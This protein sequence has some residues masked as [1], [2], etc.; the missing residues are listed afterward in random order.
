M[1]AIVKQILSIGLVSS[2]LLLA[3][4]DRS[5]KQPDFDQTL[6]EAQSYLLSGQ[7][8]SALI[9]SQNLLRMQPDSME[10]KRLLSDTFYTA[11]DYKSA[12]KNYKEILVKMDPNAPEY[13]G[14]FSKYIE[15]LTHLGQSKEAIANLDQYSKSYTVTSD[16]NRLYGDAALVSNNF[17]KATEY[18]S[19]SL[20]QNPQNSESLL[21]MA[22]ANNALGQ[23]EKAIDWLNQAIE[24][25]TDFADALIF[26][27]YFYISQKQP[28]LA[29]ASFS[30]AIAALGK[31]DIMTSQRYRAIH[32]LS[33]A[34]VDQGRTEEALRLNKTLADSPQ[35]KIQQSLKSALEAYEQGDSGLAGEYFEEVLSIS[36]DNQLSNLGLGMIKLKQGDIETAEHLLSQASK[37]LEGLNE[38][39]IKALALARLRLSKYEA[40]EDLLTKGLK[41]Y[42]DS[43]DLKVLMASVMTNK[44]QFDD[45]EAKLKEVLAKDANEPDAMN[46]LAYI[47]QDRG[48][49]KEAQDLYVKSIKVR[50]D[51]LPSYQGLIS[52]YPRSPEAA[53]QQIQQILSQQ[54]KPVI[55]TEVALAITH[56]LN[57][58]MA[59]AR[60]LS[61]K[62][63][64]KAPRN[65]YVQKVLSFSL[66]A[67]ALNDFKRKRFQPAYIQL[68]EAMD[69]MP[70]PQMATLFTRL[71]VELQRPDE[72]VQILKKLVD[73]EP[74]FTVGQELLGDLELSNGHNDKALTYFN[75]AWEQQPSFRL[76]LKVFKLKQ[77]TG[78][79]EE[80]IAHVQT[81]YKNVLADFKTQSNTPEQQR[82]TAVE[83]EA[84]LFALTT[85]YEQNNHP[86]Q[87]IEYYESL[88][89]L[90][91]NSPVYLNNIAWLKFNQNQSDAADYAAKAY[92]LAPETGEIIDTYAWILVQ[93][94]KRDKGI[95]LLQLAAEKS[96][97]NPVIKKHL[98]E[99]TAMKSKSI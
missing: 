33:K 67:S 34:Y 13:P 97:D 56:I 47:Y 40:A 25:K 73:K 86:T 90:Q 59:A 77:A 95:K 7:I 32:G 58:D 44:G 23:S 68:K 79:F 91:P 60:D 87:A 74:N 83:L 96:P 49:I 5:P 1:K 38:E 51:F 2:S 9:E 93:T 42:P 63:Y 50:P 11:G 65:L 6:F 98:E 26:Q 3:A 54:S 10:A 24:S 28:D 19:K 21:G 99:A 76:A 46:L 4:C 64:E 71:A 69:I 17:E 36:P 75:Q 84:S 14:L 89:K 43:Q 16:I 18:F 41:K 61:K 31:Y 72:A 81:W 30:Q 85:I 57:K 52:S 29:E 55:A 70:T 78:T 66:Y 94:G 15:T 39:T 80:S 37:S 92:K 82:R 88:L 35:G 22:L 48:D 27:G 62:L 45:A 53:Q 20:D 12:K 8:Q